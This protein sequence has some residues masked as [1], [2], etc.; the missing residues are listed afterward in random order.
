MSDRISIGQVA[1]RTGVAVSALRFYEEAGLI[2]P[3]RNAG[4]QRRYRRSD[5]RRVSL[6]LIAQQL[7]FSLDEIR[8]QLARLPDER[9][10][11]AKDWSRLSRSYRTILDERI[12][13]LT[14]MRDRLD[15]CI[16]CG[17][18]SLKNCAL[19]NPDVRARQRGPGPRYILDAST[20]V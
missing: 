12:D 2:H 7:G 10:P 5:I 15:G 14:R 3:E 19:Y 11:T 6:V 8:D 20:D 1:E 16:G 9:T 18:L 17:Y 13:L 4:G